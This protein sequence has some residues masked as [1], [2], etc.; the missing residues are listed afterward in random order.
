MQQ[1]IIPEAHVECEMSDSQQ[2]PEGQGGH[3][4]LISNKCKWNNSFI[5]YRLIFPN[6]FVEHGIMAHNS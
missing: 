4:H 1:T 6:L 2:D 3:N 5:K